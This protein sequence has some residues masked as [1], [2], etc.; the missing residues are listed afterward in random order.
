MTILTRMPEKRLELNQNHQDFFGGF[1]RVTANGDILDDDG[2]VLPVVGHEKEALQVWL[3]FRVN[4]QDSQ[5]Q[6]LEQ[7]SQ[8]RLWC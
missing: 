7:V 2:T 3:R 5:G 1:L 8:N 6:H 4:V